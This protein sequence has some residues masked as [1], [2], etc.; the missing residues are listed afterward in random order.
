M[1]FAPAIKMLHESIAVDI[2]KMLGTVF[3][4]WKIIPR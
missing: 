1:L 3:P 4:R 2:G